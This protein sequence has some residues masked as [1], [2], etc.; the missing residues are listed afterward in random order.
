MMHSNTKGPILIWWHANTWQGVLQFSLSAN[1]HVTSLIIKLGTLSIA[2]ELDSFFQLSKKENVFIT[3]DENLRKQSFHCLAPVGYEL[4]IS[5][6]MVQVSLVIYQLIS[7]RKTKNSIT[8]IGNLIAS[9]YIQQF[10]EPL[11]FFHT[12]SGKLDTALC[13]TCLTSCCTLKAKLASSLCTRNFAV[14]LCTC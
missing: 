1:N 11:F 4:I 10:Y 3:K 9:I 7:N 14:I 12:F 6:S 13:V 5:N 8:D 2:M